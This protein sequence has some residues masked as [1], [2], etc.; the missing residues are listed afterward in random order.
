VRD[1]VSPPYKRT[2]TIIV[3]YILILEFLERRGEYKKS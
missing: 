1:K 3:F 2:G